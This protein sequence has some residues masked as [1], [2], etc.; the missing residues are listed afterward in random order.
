MNTRISNS[1]PKRLLAQGPP[2]PSGRAGPQDQ[3]YLK[4]RLASIGTKIVL[5]Y[6]LLTL[7]VAGVGAFTVARLVTGSLQERFHNQ[8]L[9]AGRVVADGIVTDETR[10]LE[11]LNVVANTEGVPASVVAADRAALAG[12]LPQIIANSTTDALVILDRQGHEIFGW[13]RPPFRFNGGQESAGQSYA[14]FSEVQRVLSGQVDELGDRRLQLIE[15]E[16]GLIVYTIAPIYVDQTVVGAALVGTYL[17]ELVIELTQKA[18][19][20]VTFYHH[21]GDVMVTSHDGEN[22]TVVTTLSESP[23]HYRDILTELYEP[24]DWYQ[25]VVAKPDSIVLLKQLQLIDQEYTLAYGDWRMRDQSLGFFS[26]ALPSNF[27]LTA[28]ATSRNLLGLI[29]SVA[30]VAVLVLGLLIARRI[31]NPLHQ[32]VDTSVAIAEGDLARR[33]GIRSEDEIGSLARSFD[34]MTD[35]LASR[36]REL[37]EQS[38][39]L[40]AILNSAGDGLIVFDPAGRPITINPAADKILA[41]VGSNFLADVL[42]ELPPTLPGGNGAG[43]AA[44][45]SLAWATLQ[46][47]RRYELGEK[48]LSALIS[49]VTTPDGE[50]LGTVIALRDI[51]REAEAERLKDDFITSVSHELRTPLTAMQGYIDLLQLSGEGKLDPAQ[52]GYLNAINASTGKLLHHI[53]EIIDIAEI[54]A[55]KLR[56]KKEETELGSMLTTVLE[57]WRGPLAAKRLAL[58]L[59]LPRQPL[60]VKADGARLRWAIDNLLNNAHKYTL[61]GGQVEVSLFAAED[62]AWLEIRDTGVGIALADQ[63]YLFTRFFRATHPSMYEEAGVGL[64]L[65][66]TRTLIELHE[67][68]VWAASEPERGSTFSLALPLHQPAATAEPLAGEAPKARLFRR[69]R[70]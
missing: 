12:R 10:R 37:V 20:R 70:R 6:L 24:Q 49:P 38:S 16:P 64:G 46:K 18:V 23:T 39:K 57:P 1:K 43:V 67:G 34:V 21:S 33:T 52:E 2:V 13:Q 31:I 4:R 40:E 50:I 22:E 55:G 26:V 59:D 35:R 66:I 7:V 5:P 28:A 63:P 44:P 32:L 14:N 58:R 62:E 27:I 3:S 48:V 61:P 54:Q 11:I 56:L 8:L 53:N 45:E 25:Q 60:W 30:T 17:D 29:F 47:P 68:R 41:D 51:S 42:R 15:T 65:Y 19:A 69:A 36:N 9:D